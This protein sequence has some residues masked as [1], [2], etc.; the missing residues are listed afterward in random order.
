MQAAW[1]TMLC[2][3]LAFG[4]APA[5]IA[6][7][8]GAQA[9]DRETRA[10][11]RAALRAVVGPFVCTAQAPCRV[12]QIDPAVRRSRDMGL[13]DTVDRVLAR[14]EPSDVAELSTPHVL[15]ESISRSRRQAPPSDTTWLWMAWPDERGPRPATD[16]ILNVLV[17][18]DYEMYGLTLRVTLRRLS[19]GWTV[20]H[21]QPSQG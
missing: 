12:L 19:G 9:S 18:S 20:V 15:L 17:E 11:G 8:I 3:S 14:L 6:G 10:L 16:R 13:P 2:V 7:S 1:S 21:V 5:Q 4:C